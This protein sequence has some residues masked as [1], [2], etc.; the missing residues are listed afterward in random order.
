MEHTRASATAGM[1]ER[2]HVRYR[3]LGGNLVLATIL[4]HGVLTARA[5]TRAVTNGLEVHE[6]ALIL[7]PE[8]PS[9][10]LTNESCAN[11]QPGWKIM[12]GVGEGR[13]DRRSHDG[14]RRRSGLEGREGGGP[15]QG[16]ERQYADL[17]ARLLPRTA[18]VPVR[19]PGARQLAGD[20][21]SPW[22]TS[23]GTFAT[24]QMPSGSSGP[25][26]GLHCKSVLADAV[27]RN[28]A[29]SSSSPLR[30][31]QLPCLAADSLAQHLVIGPQGSVEQHDVPAVQT[32]RER[33][34]PGSAGGIK[35]SR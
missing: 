29:S 22:H 35:N 23:G 30:R 5:E 11:A 15:H 8:A 24:R 7:Q 20:P 3:C 34:H 28:A 16:R 6:T 14:P 21:L 4:T 17:S 12:P 32:L 27:C 19:D 33:C 2:D 31:T 25:A 10:L 26:V 9:H 13:G 18:P 1:T